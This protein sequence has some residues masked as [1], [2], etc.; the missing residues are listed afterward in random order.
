M[1]YDFSRRGK[2]TTVDAHQAVNAFALLNGHVNQDLLLRLIP[3][4]DLFHTGI[5]QQAL[6][7][8]SNQIFK[9][10]F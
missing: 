6:P 2:D 10:N 8:F 1:D 9:S 5:S 3:N 4:Q 7:P